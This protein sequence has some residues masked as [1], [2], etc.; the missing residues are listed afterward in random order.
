MAVTWAAKS[1]NEIRTYGLNWIGRLQGDTIASST[2]VVTDGTVT[3]SDVANTVNAITAKV[4]GGAACESAVLTNT[5]VTANGSTFEETI[6]L[7]IVADG[8]LN[9]MPSTAIKRIIVDMAFEEAA[10]A[11]YEFDL[12]ADELQTALRRLDGLMAEW[13]GQGINLNYN[14][15]ATFGQGDLD[16][17]S[18]IPDATL[19][20][21]ALYLAMR[22]FPRFNKVMKAGTRIAL[23]NAMMTIRAL[24]S[25]TPLVQYRWGTPRGAGN[26]RFG[27]LSPFIYWTDCSC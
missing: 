22:I 9:A 26:R 2:L 12:T 3:L 24:G 21:A 7:S 16:D 18:G 14:Q 17:Q 4:S 5:I 15:P 11:G 27:S 13:Q 25:K 23:A 8:S 6:T 20:G 1:P 10:L 19:N